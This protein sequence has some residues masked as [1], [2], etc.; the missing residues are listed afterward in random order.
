MSF[1]RNIFTNPKYVLVIYEGPNPKNFRLQFYTLEGTFKGEVP[2]PGQPN[3]KMWYDKNGNFLYSL[4][5][6]S[7]KGVYFI[8]KYKILE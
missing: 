1:V 3:W 5:N 8:L 2:I 6:N 4:S 7:D